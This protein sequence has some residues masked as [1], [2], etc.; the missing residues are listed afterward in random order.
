MHF[1]SN[2]IFD[3]SFHNIEFNSENIDDDK[4]QEINKLKIISIASILK[5][6]INFDIECFH[7]SFK[8]FSNKDLQIDETSLTSKIAKELDLNLYIENIDFD[9]NF[10]SYKNLIN[11]FKQPNDNISALMNYQ[12]NK[13]ISKKY[14]CF[15][16]R[17]R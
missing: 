11:I 13:S 4:I 10:F 8:R 16:I 9:E 2:S 14:Q 6:E 1:Y 15:F 3:S 5:K 17:R 12:I 7:A